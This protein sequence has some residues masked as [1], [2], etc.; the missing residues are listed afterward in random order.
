MERIRDASG[1]VGFLTDSE[2]VAEYILIISDK[3]VFEW[4]DV[5]IVERIIEAIG[6][7][8][9]SDGALKCEERDLEFETIRGH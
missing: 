2:C 4:Q 8:G 6:T 5:T 1:R 7:G 3:W 9:L